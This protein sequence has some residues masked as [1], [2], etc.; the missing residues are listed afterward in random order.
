M[1]RANKGPKVSQSVV[2]QDARCSPTKLGPLVLKNEGS[3]LPSFASVS[4]L[5]SSIIA[6]YCGGGN[7][8][9]FVS[10]TVT[11]APVGSFKISS[12]SL[13]LGLGPQS[14]HKQLIGVLP[15]P[16]SYGFF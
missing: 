16:D 3:C 10:A 8:R 15:D 13:R 9:S 5:S 11:L 6:N 7:G 4:V 1:L 12:S 14:K 2:A